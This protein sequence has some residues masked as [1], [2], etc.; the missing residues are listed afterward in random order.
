M[1][2]SNLKFRHFA[3]DA[4]YKAMNV[5]V[6]GDDNDPDRRILIAEKSGDPLRK[7]DITK[8]EYAELRDQWT[9]NGRIP[10]NDVRVTVSALEWIGA[11][12]KS[13][14]TG[15][16]NASKDEAEK[17][18]SFIHARCLPA[19]KARWVK[20]AQANGVKLTEWIVSALNEK[21]DNQAR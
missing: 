20:A 19:D 4:H 15:N 8:S 16:Q 10:D 12:E 11:F 1:S 6:Y 13:G 3:G 9:D 17:A 2:N 14:Y 21:A 5:A 18:S 7:T